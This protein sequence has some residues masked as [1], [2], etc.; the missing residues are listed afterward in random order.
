[1]PRTKRRFDDVVQPPE[2]S[3][4]DDDD[5]DDDDD[6]QGTSTTTTH[7]AYPRTTFGGGKQLN[8]MMGGGKQIRLNQESD[9]D[10]DDD[11]DN[12]NDNDGDSG[13]EEEEEDSEEE[14]EQ[15]PQQSMVYNRGFGGG[16]ILRPPM[17]GGKILRQASENSEEE[18]EEEDSDSGEESPPPPPPPP[19]QQQPAYRYSGGGKGIMQHQ[20]GG[21]ILKY[22][23][24][25]SS[26]SEDE[27]EEEENNQRV[28]FTGNHRGGGKVLRKPEPEPSE[29]EVSE[30]E[31]EVVNKQEEPEA[32]E[33]EDDMDIPEESDAEEEEEEE[34]VEPPP[35]PEPTPVQASPERKTRTRA[36]P[37]RTT[38]QKSKPQIESES[39]NDMD[40][41]SDDEMGKSDES[42]EEESSDSEEEAELDMDKLDQKDLV[43]DEAD[44]KYLES[45]PEIERESILGQR[46]EKRKAD[47]DM[48]KVLR[49]NTRKE[50]EKKRMA[51]GK[52]RKTSKQKKNKKNTKKSAPKKTET[53]VK[54]TTNLVESDED[55]DDEFGEA[56]DTSGDAKFAQE[57]ALNRAAKT[58]DASG[59]VAKRRLAL[60]KL[61]K[62][63]ATTADSNESDNA[64]DD[65]GS[66][67]S[68][69]NSDEEFVGTNKPWMANKKAS[70]RPSVVK[71]SEDEDE[72][73]LD[74]RGTQK[75]FV[76]ADL[77]D[78]LKV[79]IPRR[80][81][82]RWCNEPYFQEALKE[83]YVRLAIGR[84]QKTSKPCYRLCKIV[85]VVVG[86]SDYKLPSMNGKS[87]TTNKKLTLM[88]G[89]SKR[90]F[91]MDTISDS[92]PTEEDVKQYL[93]QL[94]N[95]RGGAKHALSKKQASTMRKR[96]DN[97]I[98]NFT[99]TTEDVEKSVEITKAM[100][101]KISNIGAEKT[102]VSIAVQA[103]MASLEDARNQEKE[104]E[105][106]AFEVDD[107]DEV[108]V[109]GELNNMKDRVKELEQDY[110]KK[111]Q[112]Q[113]K[114]L[115]AEVSRSEKSRNNNK[116]RD[117]AAV[118][119][120][121]K[122]ANKNADA[123]AY[124]HDRERGS[125]TIFGRRKVQKV[126]LWNVGQEKKDE[127][128]ENA[129]GDE[130]KDQDNNAKAGDD[131]NESNANNENSGD[132][133]NK[134][135]LTEQINEMSIDEE[136]IPRL[137]GNNTNN[138]SATTRV[139]KGLS[140][141]EYLERKAA[142]GA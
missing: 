103:A 63:R 65:F 1:M 51:S 104:L 45:L 78:F 116:I 87:V 101:K 73:F 138:K 15:Q 42:S 36:T 92:R 72:G 11:N 113:Q 80:R 50:K 115:N 139:R 62:D 56:P 131:K 40:V 134:S 97:L 23:P 55:D 24:S 129:T 111:L 71:Y 70:S 107:V 88:F 13:D 9:D 49:E 124:K 2:S 99:Y 77:S 52:K 122:Q 44:R 136:A 133:H 142:L 54:K 108:K 35:E 117:W 100:N 98:N 127:N 105:R 30:A 125:T 12:E 67:D 64:M 22:A 81:I 95:R 32:E 121:A 47:M 21:K 29:D 27:Q 135:K 110:Q 16:K 75:T 106:K 31:E 59:A 10:S 61:R 60:A 37:T 118:N 19:P 82:T 25:S 94:K 90:P 18:E 132:F 83:F 5:D 26:G 8:R 20:R 38:R 76:E 120:R 28:S 141:T 86:G 58:R 33:E 53:S 74:G 140:L 102:R 46:F 119:R 84:D 123:E 85:D 17:G 109:Q 128:S 89:D 39:E 96:Q 137:M 57:L 114:V 34:K 91:R 68:D 41:S 130:K 112:E 69:D 4:S 6:N 43:E 3:D 14:E 48:Q 126:I 66:D 79:T 7:T 93:D